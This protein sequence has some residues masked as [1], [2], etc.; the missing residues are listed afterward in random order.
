M[1]TPSVEMWSQNGTYS[2]VR[3]RDA[4]LV[5]RGKGNEKDRYFVTNGTTREIGIKTVMVMKREGKEKESK[6]H[7]E[8]SETN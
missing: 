4:R 5:G 1:S 6:C 8:R 7:S 3:M 2:I